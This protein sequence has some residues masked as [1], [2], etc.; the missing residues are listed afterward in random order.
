M[1]VRFRTA[2]WSVS[3][4]FIV[5][6]L[7]LAFRPQPVLIDVATSTRGPM[8]VTVRD[9]GRTRVRDEYVVSAPVGSR[10]LRVPFKPG[11]KVEAGETVA[12][13]LP[14]SPAFLDARAQGEAQAAVRSAE[15][16]VEVARAELER[17]DEQLT[18]ART[19][20]QR[21]ESLRGG[22]LVS[23]ESY[24][25]AQLEL[26]TAQSA[27]VA[28]SQALRIREAELQAAGVRLT[29]PGTRA[30]GR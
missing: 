15:A 24:D 9:E 12:R 19:E 20:A 17:A 23:A 29:Q 22:G 21:V 6:L 5:L 1:K 27:Q 7:V 26:R 28:A 13:I 10:L 30:N 4:A 25:R 11:A 3:A 2:F 14:G 16:A 8:Q 18:F